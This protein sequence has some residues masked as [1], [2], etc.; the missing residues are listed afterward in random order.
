MTLL[1]RHLAWEAMERLGGCPGGLL[2]AF[3]VHEGDAF[4]WETFDFRM[5]VDGGRKPD[6]IIDFLRGHCESHVKINVV[7]CTHN[8][9]DHAH[10]LIGLLGDPSIEIGEI[11]LPAEF[12]DSLIESKRVGVD[13]TLQILRKGIPVAFEPMTALD[14]DS[15]VGLP[16][17]QPA[18]ARHQRDDGIRSAVHEAPEDDEPDATLLPD[19]LGEQAER[20]LTV[21]ASPQATRGGRARRGFSKAHAVDAMKN[22]ASI[23][24]LAWQ[25]RIPIV[26][27]RAENP[28]PTRCFSRYGV[29]VLNATPIARTPPRGIILDRLLA[30]TTQNERALVLRVGISCQLDPGQCS[31]ALFCSDSRLSFEGGVIDTNVFTAP[32]HGSDANDSAYRHLPLGALAIRSDR[33]MSSGGERPSAGFL[34][35]ERRMCTR[36]RGSDATQTVRVWLTC[37]GH[38]APAR[39]CL[40]VPLGGPTGSSTNRS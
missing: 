17:R 15:D 2:T 7:A 20:V 22:I 10:G 19:E 3:P 14:L 37:H 35:H 21:L 13:E 34:A 27:L 33:R 30:L 25:R 9:A 29:E 28:A 31:R 24:K 36:C 1:D 16:T 40:C 6:Q 23:A 5:L 12:C 39:H 26:W 11:W 32:H 18:T 4:L 8:D 38:W